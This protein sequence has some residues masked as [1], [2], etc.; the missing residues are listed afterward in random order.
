MKK[1]LFLSVF[2][3]MASCNQSISQ[4]TINEV[5]KN[6]NFWKQRDK[7]STDNEK[8]K[9]YPIKKDRIVNEKRVNS[10]DIHSQSIQFEVYVDDVLLYNFKGEASQHQGGAIG[11]H[12]I[13]PLLL[14]SG[15]HEVKVR[16]YPAL[17]QNVFGDAGGLNLIFFHY[18]YPDLK[19][20]TYNPAMNGAEGIFLDQQKE[21]WAAEKGE[22]GKP[23]YVEARYEPKIALPLK[24]LPVYE[25]RSTFEADVPFDLVGWRNSVNLK[26]EFEDDKKLKDEVIAEYRKIYEIIKNKDKEKF[27]Q[28]IKDREELTSQTLYY[29]AA[30]KAAR[31]NEFLKLLQNDEYEIEPLFEETFYLEFQ[32]YGK[33]VSILNKADKEGII[34]LKNKKKPDEKVYL[35]FL[36]QKKK[37]GDKL[38]VI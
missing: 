26:K 3:I 29:G 20:V 37:K 28:L 24:G 2:L 22:Y 27:L 9:E 30:E 18:P 13:N 8:D 14:T 31:S 23:G 32:G 1:I 10:I 34:R 36:F 4:E 11:A 6:E 25:W 19:K 5:K 33:L 12:E 21:Y 17:G 38:S 35:D 7:M 15:T 16:M